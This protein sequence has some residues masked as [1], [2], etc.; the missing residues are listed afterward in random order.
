MLRMV[1]AALR[2]KVP[3][4]PFD[5]NAPCS[6][7]VHM[8]T[9]A[10]EYLS[11]SALK[12][13]SNST[14]CSGSE[15]LHD[16][17]QIELGDGH[18]AITPALLAELAAPFGL[19]PSSVTVWIRYGQD[20][21]DVGEPEEDELVPTKKSWRNFTR[22]EVGDILVLEDTPAVPAWRLPENS[23]LRWYQSTLIAL[24]LVPV[25]RGENLHTVL[26]CCFC[27]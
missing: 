14:S 18:T 6:F 19:T 22:M 1:T 13:S 21:D 10:L 20:A 16:V 5:V 17:R 27:V 11:F 24:D 7:L 25:S 4:D 12:P 8:Y 23:L 15:Q 3:I 26:A 2:S 9:P